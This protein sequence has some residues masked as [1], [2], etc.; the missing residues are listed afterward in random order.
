MALLD[1]FSN[2][3]RLRAGLE[4]NGKDPT[5]VV[6][7]AVNSATEGVVNGRTTILAGTNNYLGLTFDPDCIAAGVAALRSTGYWYDRFAYGK[8]ELC[9]TWRT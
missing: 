7:D 5:T 2:A 3:Q 9:I 8:W 1:K 4:N 6:F